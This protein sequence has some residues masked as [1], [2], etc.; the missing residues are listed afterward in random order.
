MRFLL[1]GSLQTTVFFK[2]VICALFFFSSFLNINVFYKNAGGWIRTPVVWWRKRP[3]CQLCHNHCPIQI[4]DAV[5]LLLKNVT[6]LNFI[7]FALKI[8]HYGLNSQQKYY[9]KNAFSCEFVAKKRKCQWIF[10]L[11]RPIQVIEK[12]EVGS[13][14]LKQMLS[15]N[16]SLS[17]HHS[18]LPKNAQTH[19]HPHCHH[20]SQHIQS[21][22]LFL[23]QSRQAQLAPDSVTR[24]LDYLF[25]ILAM[26]KNEVLPNS[27]NITKVDE[28]VCQI[29]NKQSKN[30]Q[31]LLNF[32]LGGEISPNLVTLAAPDS[33][34][35]S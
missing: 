17:P 2:Q 15:K 4:I 28:I 18:F 8:M 29:V 32:C 13:C 19:T 20:V 25:N 7:F 35:R 6:K 10:I 33:L 5:D 24:W 12:M 22:S 9:N 21:L 3:V 23:M 26:H 27:K 11:P 14:L 34:A 31:I 1:H 30:C 16:L